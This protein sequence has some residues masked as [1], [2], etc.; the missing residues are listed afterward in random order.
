MSEEH[1]ANEPTKSGSSVQSASDCSEPAAGPETCEPVASILQTEGSLQKLSAD[2][3]MA[4]Y[5][6]ELKENDWG[7]QPC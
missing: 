5:E 3:Q 2:E 4:L 6:K 7:H 1:K